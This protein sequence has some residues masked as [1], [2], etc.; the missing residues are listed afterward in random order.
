MLQFLDVDAVLGRIA[1][2]RRVR[3]G[4]GGVALF[5]AVGVAVAHSGVSPYVAIL[6]VMRIGGAHLRTRARNSPGKVGTLL[7]IRRI[8]AAAL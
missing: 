3:H 7:P 4:D 2:F 5:H 6:P 8:A 1:R